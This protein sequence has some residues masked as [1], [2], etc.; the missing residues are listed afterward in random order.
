MIMIIAV[1]GVA[2]VGL[3]NYEEWYDSSAT[4]NADIVF[5]GS[6]RVASGINAPLVS[7]VVSD[8]VEYRVKVTN[9]GRGGSTI[10]T[11]YLELRELIESGRLEQPIVLLELAGEVPA[12]LMRG[13]WDERWFHPKFPSLLARA[14]T[15]DDVD[16]FLEADHSRS[17]RFAVLSRYAFN[18]SDLI[19]FKDGWRD[20]FFDRGGKA[21]GDVLDLFLPTTKGD[22]SGL[23]DAGGVATDAAGVE[24]ARE[25]AL[26][27]LENESRTGVV[28]DDWNAT[29][30]ASLVQLVHDNGGRFVF[31]QMPVSSVF[32][33]DFETD[34]HK[35]NRTN[36]ASSMNEWGTPLI[37]FDPGLDDE[38][39]PDL[40]HLGKDGADITSEQ[41][42]ELLAQMIAAGEP[43]LTE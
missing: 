29:V 21:T 32:E 40:W 14:M 7:Q 11:H 4:H 35:E 33:I 17:E 28:L 19:S 13:T 42:G 23:S 6:S 43:G 26:E 27:R 20:L 38:S 9:Q 10:V 31:F 12:P 16:P 18:N 8:E 24:R 2:R 5:I 36:F 1:E 25:L 41:L 34:V 3:S 37:E 39:F 22:G 15:G 30:L